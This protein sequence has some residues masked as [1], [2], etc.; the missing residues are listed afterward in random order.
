MEG[1]PTGS[2]PVVP[3]ATMALLVS[4]GFLLAAALLLTAE[5]ATGRSRLG[6]AAIVWG[7]LGVYAA[8]A[9][10]GGALLVALPW[11]EWLLMLALVPL[12]SICLIRFVSLL[13]ERVPG[14]RGAAMAGAVLAVGLIGGTSALPVPLTRAEIQ[15]ALPGT[16]PL[17]AHPDAGRLVRT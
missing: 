6:G 12:T 1:P 13:Q 7:S 17:S 9:S 15:A 14:W 5:V 2:F 16:P 8:A 11:A 3:F 10:A 4:F